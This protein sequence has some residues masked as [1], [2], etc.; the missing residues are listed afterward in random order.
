MKSVRLWTPPLDK[1]S[2]QA[3]VM[4]DLTQLEHPLKA[5]IIN[6]IYYRLRRPGLINYIPVLTEVRPDSKIR[7]VLQLKIRELVSSL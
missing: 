6:S 1:S 3:P 7:N 2:D 5:R 4:L